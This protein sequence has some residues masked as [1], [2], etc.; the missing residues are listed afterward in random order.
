MA[1]ISQKPRVISTISVH[2]CPRP[3][4]NLPQ[5]LHGSH[6]SETSCD[7]HNLCPSMS[8]THTQ[9]T[10]T[11]TWLSFLRNLVWYPQSLSIHVRDPYTNVIGRFLSMSPILRIIGCFAQPNFDERDLN[12]VSPLK[13]WICRLTQWSNKYE[14]RH[15][16]S[17]NVVFWQSVDSFDPV[18]PPFKLRNSKWC[19][20]SSLT[21]IEYSSNRR[22]LGSDCAYA[23]ADLRLCWSFITHW[24]K[25]HVA[26]HIP[27]WIH[28]EASLQNNHV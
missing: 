10:S 3:I 21:V 17:N 7:I 13:L 15:V 8:E 22:R 23:Q 18:L 16:I 11:S 5:H 9:L 28:A 26:A 25:T 24:W 6:F 27:H 14:L 12:A 20:V 2:P 19:S 4:H 1:L